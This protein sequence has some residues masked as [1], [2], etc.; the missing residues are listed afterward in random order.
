MPTPTSSATVATPDLHCFSDAA[1]DAIYQTI[2]SRRDVRSQFLPT[3]VSDA[4]LSRILTAAHFAPSVG[5]MQPWNFLLVQSAEIKQRV[6]QAY[7]SANAEAAQMFEAQQ[8]SSYQ[9][10]KLEGIR[11]APLAICITCDRTRGGDVVL[12]RTHIKTMDVYSSVCAVQ[13]LWLAAR[14]EGLGVGWVSIFHEAQ[15]Q[16]ALGIPAHIVPIAYLCV[17]Y[18]SHFYPQPELQSKGWRGRL[19]LT[20][21]VYFDQW[22]QTDAEHALLAH[23]RRDQL[24]AEVIAE[25]AAQTDS[26]A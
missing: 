10:L 2:F 3:P 7:L 24:A 15:L 12:G 17:G 11:E 19:P 16:Q 6:A 8:R 23:L 26:P 5:F 18:V 1:R 14:A 25:R 13:N 21:L 4:V 22:G 20:D 9:Q